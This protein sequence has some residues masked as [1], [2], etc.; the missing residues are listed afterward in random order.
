MVSIVIVVTTPR[1]NTGVRGEIISIR[2]RFQ[3]LTPLD[4]V[5]TN[6]QR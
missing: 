5:A 4:Q 1:G 3:I 2:W 6:I